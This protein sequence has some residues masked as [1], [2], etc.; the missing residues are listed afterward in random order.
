MTTAGQG[1]TPTALDLLFGRNAPGRALSERAPVS[2][3]AA[4]GA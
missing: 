2:G 1:T 3:N 4:R